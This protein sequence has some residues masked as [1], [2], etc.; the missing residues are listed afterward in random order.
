MG[1]IIKSSLEWKE[2][3]SFETEV[4]GHKFMLDADAAVGGKD[5]G[6]R[7]KPLLLTALSG[8]TAMD[9]I[10][11][12][13]KMRVELERFN[14]EV[15]ANSTEEHPKYYDQITLIYRFKGKDLPM[16]KLEKAVKLSQE[17][18]CGVSFMLGKAANID[19]KIVVE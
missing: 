8:C 17:N 18:Y 10:S 13:K 5:R 2:G 9:V 7:P 16:E 15:E 6:P 1:K 11:I 19:Y 3:M 14:V 12:L 4:N